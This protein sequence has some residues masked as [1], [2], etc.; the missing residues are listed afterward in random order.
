MSPGTWPFDKP[1]AWT[2]IRNGLLYECPINGLRTL[3]LG[4]GRGSPWVY[5]STSTRSAETGEL[6]DGPSLELGIGSGSMTVDSRGNIYAVDLVPS[7]NPSKNDLL[8]GFPNHDQYW[9]GYNSTLYNYHFY[10][11]ETPVTHQNQVIEVVKFG[12]EGGKRLTDAEL[13]AHR[14]A[15]FFNAFCAGCSHHGDMLACDAADRI[16]AGDPVHHCVKV[17]DTAGNLIQWIGCYGNAET[18]P[19]K[20]ASAEELGFHNIYTVAAAGESLFVS[21]RDLRRVAHV[22]MDYRERK[23]VDFSGKPLAGGQ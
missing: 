1:V 9:Q 5:V 7:G 4:K 2:A 3:W 15:G 23:S 8:F 22:A 21:D 13:W 18:V 6:T 14:G 12:P 19:P 17:L 11:A 16:Y 10:R 20:G